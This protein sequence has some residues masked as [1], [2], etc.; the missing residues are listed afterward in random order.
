MVKVVEASS[1]IPSKG[2]VVIDF[3][4]T[5]CG[6]CQRIGPIYAGL[7]HTFPSI[8]FLKVDVDDAEELS[9]S[10]S[11]QSLPTFV[12]L[13]NG[14]VYHRIEGADIYA[15]IKTLEDLMSLE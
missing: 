2:Q 6:P 14:V 5:W 9:E 15:V 8:T 4:A 13:N 11:I 1:E 12:F 3:S 10:Y 7:E